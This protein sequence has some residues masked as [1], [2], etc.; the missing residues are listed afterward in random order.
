MRAER[1]VFKSGAHPS[2]PITVPPT[3]EVHCQKRA[4]VDQ[5]PSDE[6]VRREEANSLYSIEFLELK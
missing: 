6:C 3:L 5:T 4:G 1:L 2:S